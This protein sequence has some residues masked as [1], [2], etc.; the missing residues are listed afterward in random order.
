MNSKPPT[1]NSSSSDLTGDLEALAREGLAQR[2]NPAN[3]AEVQRMARTL[4]RLR[5]AALSAAG[6]A[7][8]QVQSVGDP[9][10]QAF[11]LTL[12]TLAS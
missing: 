2:L 11:H 6:L 10:A 5:P 9:S 8:S 7:T 1:S 4:A 3:P 12:K